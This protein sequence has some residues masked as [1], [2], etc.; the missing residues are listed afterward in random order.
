MAELSQKWDEAFDVV[1]IG[2]GFAGLAAAIEA[3]NAG[4][5][6]TVL[7]KMKYCGGN[8]MISDGLVAAAG[9]IFQRKHRIQDSPELMQNDMVKAGLGLNHPDL[10]R[11]VA[12]KSNEALQWTMDYIGVEYVDRV[13]QLGGHSVPR[14]H[15]VKGHSSFHTGAFLLRK[16]MGFVK[17]LGV[18]VRTQMYLTKL[19]KDEDGSI[20]GVQIRQ[21]Y[22]FPESDSGT[23]KFLQ[24]KKGVVL[25]TG[26]FSS[27]IDFRTI[28]DPRLTSEVESTNR[29]GA[30]AEALI[31]AMRIGATPIQLSWIQLGPWASPD[32]KGSGVGS[33]FASVSIFPYGIIIDPKTG[34]R[35]VKESADRKIR[36]DAILKVG[37]PSIGITDAEG[38]KYGKHMLDRCLKKNVLKAFQNLK[39]LSVFYKIPNEELK[40]TVE[41]FNRYVKSNRDGAFEKMILT[42][43]Q[44]LIRPPFYA[45]RLWPKVHHTMGGIQINKNAQVIGL[46]KQPIKQLYAA[47]EVTGGIHGACRLGSCAIIDCLVFGRM[48]GRNV[49]LNHI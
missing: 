32:E 33:S 6:V 22:V 10:V 12:E 35:F 37:R 38:A 44:P 49:A 13:S 43:A 21:G 27:D 24:A 20:R 47:G 28:Q 45:I 17:E 15:S 40:D 39:D 30:T 18:E 3:K 25:T 9:S 4:A 1:V 19:L 34:K 5:S 42:D 31:E 48:A 26:G 46:N 29:Q 14:T 7:E 2:S 36:A 41:K 16:M 11:T 23:V 8:S